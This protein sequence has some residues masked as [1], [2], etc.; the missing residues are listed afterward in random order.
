LSWDGSHHGNIH[1]YGNVHNS[2]I[3]HPEFGEK[4]YELTPSAFKG[5]MDANNI[6][7][8]SIKEIVGLANEKI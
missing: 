2:G 6:Y 3:M 1:L 5:G 4:L 7:P 8:M